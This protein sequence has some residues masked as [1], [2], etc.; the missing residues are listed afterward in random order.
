M[1]AVEIRAEIQSYLEKVQDESFLKV[2]HSMLDAYVREHEDPII[3]YDVDGVPLYASVAEETV[4]RTAGGGRTRRVHHDRGPGKRNG[5]MVTYKVVV[6]QWLRI[7]YAGSVAASNR[8]LLP[9]WR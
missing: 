1:S 4:Q 8:K 7:V 6:T 3:G 2:V 9:K 5:K